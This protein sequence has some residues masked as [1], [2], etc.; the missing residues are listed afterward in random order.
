MGSNLAASSRAILSKRR[1]GMDMGRNMTPANLYA[2]LTLMATLMLLPLSALV[3]G[4]RLK[5][6]WNATVENYA[7][8]CVFGS[9][10]RLSSADIVRP[11]TTAVCN[12]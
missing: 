4:P 6:L 9:M 10:T 3:E 11:R 12:T 1:M 8:G 7:D 2:V 5:S